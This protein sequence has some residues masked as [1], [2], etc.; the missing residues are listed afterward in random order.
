MQSAPPVLTPER[1]DAMLSRLAEVGMEAV[2]EAGARLKAAGDEEAFERCGRTLNAACRNLRQTFAMK[3]RFDRNQARI[4]AERRS[5]AEDAHKEARKV[6]EAAVGK[7]SGRVREQLY[8]LIWNEH[9]PD[10]VEDI[11]FEASDRL[12]ELSEDDGFLDTPVETLLARL[13]AECGIGSSRD[14]S[15]ASTGP[16]S[17]PVRAAGA[18]SNRR[19]RGEGAED[20]EDAAPLCALSA[21][22]APSAVESLGGRPTATPPGHLSPEPP[23]RPPDPPP[24]PPYLPPW[25]RNP[26]AIIRGGSGW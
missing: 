7:H 25:E 18:G 15:P 20:A 16:G 9:E 21:A 19:D 1:I 14:A 8:P 17:E 22:S 6:R 23:P 2:E 11:Y 24:D 4:A 5:E 12:D 26:H 13:T 3:E 10:E